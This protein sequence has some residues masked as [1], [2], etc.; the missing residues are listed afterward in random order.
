MRSKRLPYEIEIVRLEARP[1]AVVRRRAR[2]DEL[3]TVVPAACGEVWKHVRAA[4]VKGAGRHVAVYLDGQ[5]TLEVGVEVP[6][7][8]VGSG[9]VFLSATPAGAVARTVHMGPYRLLSRAHSAIL[10][11]CAATDVLLAG[12]NWEIYGHWN[13]DPAQLRTDVC[14]LLRETDGT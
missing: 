10:D 1:I 2:P 9:D 3:S 8:F 13:D 12:P 11:W 6:S 14:Y 5:I 7:T 4:E